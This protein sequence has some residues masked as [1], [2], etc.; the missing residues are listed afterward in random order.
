[1]PSRDA[2]GLPQ[3]WREPRCWTVSREANARAND[4]I[5][6]RREPQPELR[7][8]AVE[9]AGLRVEAQTHGAFDSVQPDIRQLHLAASN[10]CC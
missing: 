9:L 8:V 2:V 7:R 3:A 1:V 5:L 4:G 6:P 10:V